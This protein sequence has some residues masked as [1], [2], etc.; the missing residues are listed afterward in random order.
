MI[1][2]YRV[3]TQSLSPTLYIKCLVST[4]SRY[5]L[6]FTGEVIEAYHPKGIWLGSEGMVL[7][8]KPGSPCCYLDCVTF[9]PH[10]RKAPYLP[11]LG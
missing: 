7:V 1:K 8:R 3:L 9:S 10:L 2:A 11:E 5:Y 4:T 6:H